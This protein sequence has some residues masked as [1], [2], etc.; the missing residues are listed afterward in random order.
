MDFTARAF[1]WASAVP[2]PMPHVPIGASEHFRGKPG[3]GLYADIIQ[4]ID[5]SVALK[6][7]GLD[8][9][10]LVIFTSD[11]GPWFNFGDPA[12]PAG[13]LREGKAATF[14]GGN[15]VPSLVRWPGNVPAGRVCNKLL[16]NMDLLPMIASITG[17]RLPKKKIDGVD[18]LALLKGDAAETP[19]KHSVY[20]YQKTV[21]RLFG[22]AIGN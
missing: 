1:T 4:E 18:G 10:T 21:W 20:Y 22:K 14:E 2:H 15:R 3:K 8:K 11:N 12:G 13:D 17:A 9:N 5:W 19:R 6:R 16:T 7:N